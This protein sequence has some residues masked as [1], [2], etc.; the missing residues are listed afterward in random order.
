MGLATMALL[1]HRDGCDDSWSAECWEDLAGQSAGRK[2]PYR[3]CVLTYTD[4][5]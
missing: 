2:T 5:V 4:S 3:L 1:G